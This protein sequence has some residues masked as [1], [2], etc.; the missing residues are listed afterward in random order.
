[1]CVS[2]LPD[3][4]D[5]AHK[6]LIGK[7]LL[8][9]GG[10]GGVYDLGSGYSVEKERMRNAF[11]LIEICEDV[12]NDPSLAPAD[13]KTYCNIALHRIAVKCGVSYFEGKLAN[14]ICDLVAGHKD[15]RKE[16]D[17]A[18]VQKHAN[19]GGLAIAAQ[20]DTPHGHVAVVAP[21]MAVPSGKWGK[22]APIVANVGKKNGIMGANFA[23]AT[24]PDFY[25]H[26][27]V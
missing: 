7:L 2:A 25:L 26:G 4:W 9:K 8:P 10:V 16:A 5:R 23:F 13:G 12:V 1:M 11:K 17:L 27:E 20:K 14:D 15:W 3:F 19:S 6:K 24:I 21:G 22:D 18:R